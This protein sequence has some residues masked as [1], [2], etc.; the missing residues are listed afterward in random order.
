LREQADDLDQQAV[1]SIKLL[2]SISSIVKA[3]H[4][5]HHATQH[6][7]T[8]FDLTRKE[9]LVQASERSDELI[10]TLLEREAEIVKLT[11]ALVAQE[12][13][14]AEIYAQRQ[15]NAEEA[16]ANIAQLNQVPPFVFTYAV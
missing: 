3:S 10:S 11:E 9:A 8:D 5:Q 16:E 7:L 13:Q 4:S 15:A 1:D 12:K 14:M 6:D 2:N